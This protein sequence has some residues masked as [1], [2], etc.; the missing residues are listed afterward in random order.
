[1]GRGIIMV[2]GFSE[3]EMSSDGGVMFEV[4]PT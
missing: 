2:I 3:G 1:M 4:H